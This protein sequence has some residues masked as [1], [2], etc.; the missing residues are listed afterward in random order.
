MPDAF[1][2]GADLASALID[3]GNLLKDSGGV[4]T[5]AHQKANESLVPTL[6]STAESLQGVS[7]ALRSLPAMSNYVFMTSVAAA[8]FVIIGGFFLVAAMS[9]L[10]SINAQEGH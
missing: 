7:K 9:A 6:R 5:A 10:T 2:P 8:L 4:L 3:K 1:K